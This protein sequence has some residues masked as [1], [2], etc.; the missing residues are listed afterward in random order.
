M[1][2]VEAVRALQD[3][4]NGP[5]LRYDAECVLVDLGWPALAIRLAAGR[6]GEVVRTEV[7]RSWP[8]RLIPGMWY[9]IR[10]ITGPEDRKA[11]FV[12]I[13]G[14]GKTEYRD[15]DEKQLQRLGRTAD[16]LCAW[17]EAVDNYRAEKAT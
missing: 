2:E 1:D 6:W 12:F 14:S 10:E 17:D 9:E 16:R 5:S 13:D 7:A 3:K 15:A 11:G 4:L 8:A